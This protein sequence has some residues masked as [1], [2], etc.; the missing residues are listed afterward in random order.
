[1]AEGYR[2][3]AGGPQPACRQVPAPAQPLLLQI[4][5]LPADFGPLACVGCG[6]C[7]DQCPVNVDITEVLQQIAARTSPAVTSV[8]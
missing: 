1:M 5:L 3:I 7:I 6:R 4:R 8:D 2:R